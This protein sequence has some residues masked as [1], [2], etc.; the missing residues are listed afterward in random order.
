MAKGKKKPK[1]GGKK[2]SPALDDVFMSFADFIGNTPEEWK[3]ACDFIAA[4]SLANKPNT[5][6]NA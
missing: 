1:G 4:V 3:L 6:T 2:C 5:F